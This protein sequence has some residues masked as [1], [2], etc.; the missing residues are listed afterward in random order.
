MKTLTSWLTNFAMPD[1]SGFMALECDH[2]T[3]GDPAGVLVVKFV[4]KQAM[5]LFL[6]LLLS[7]SEK[8]NFLR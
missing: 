3:G 5:F 6:L 8:H 1:V 7:F 2:S 4:Q